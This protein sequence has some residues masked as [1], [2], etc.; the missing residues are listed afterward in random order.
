[1][2]YLITVFLWYLRCFFSYIIKSKS[3]SIQTKAISLADFTK[4]VW[5]I[6][7]GQWLL[8]WWQWDYWWDT[9]SGLLCAVGWP[10]WKKIDRLDVSDLAGYCLCFAVNSLAI[11]FIKSHRP[12]LNIYLNN[13]ITVFLLSYSSLVRRHL[14]NAGWSRKARKVRYE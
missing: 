13:A 6:H 12:Q 7:R 4:G 8:A 5:P 3:A 10:S 1:M 2:H 11:Y 9:T 14:A